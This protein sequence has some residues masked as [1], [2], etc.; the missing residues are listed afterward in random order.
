MHSTTDLLLPGASAQ[1]K[2]G[3][4]LVDPNNDSTQPKVLF[5][6]DHTPA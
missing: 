4:V 5:M 1:I 2:T 3:A 6:V